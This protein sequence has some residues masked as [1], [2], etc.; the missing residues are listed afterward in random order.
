MSTAQPTQP[1][2]N[3]RIILSHTRQSSQTWVVP[4]IPE[5]TLGQILN[6]IGIEPERF[7]P[8]AS[9]PYV[10]VNEGETEMPSLDRNMLD[11]NNWYVDHG[12]IP[13]FYIKR[14]SDVTNSH[15]W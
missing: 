1:S 8:S 13:S 2:A 12:F 6:I 3:I 14:R 9:D 11:Y 5:T 7:N 15:G 4:V 10:F